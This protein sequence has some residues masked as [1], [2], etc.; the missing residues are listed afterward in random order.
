MT[1]YRGKKEERVTPNEFH[2]LALALPGAVEAAHGGHPDF[3]ASRRKRIF[4]TLGYPDN[5]WAMIKLSPDQQAFAD[6]IQIKA[7]QLSILD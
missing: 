1:Y 4:A 7:P 2:R 6:R 3:R 5:A